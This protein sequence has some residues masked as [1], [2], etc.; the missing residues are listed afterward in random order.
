MSI[1]KI[2]EELLKFREER[3]WAQFHDPKNL[4]EAISIE[5]NELLQ[6]FLWKNKEEIEHKI[7]NDLEYREEIEDELADVLTY[8]VQMS[9]RLDIDIEQIIFK[10]L[11]KVRSKYPV[12]KAKGNANKYTKL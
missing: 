10:K 11:E 5:A 2:K 1:E 12:E 6:L 7:K 4:A 3:E 9:N 8:C